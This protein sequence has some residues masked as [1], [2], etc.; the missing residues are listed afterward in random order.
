MGIR[1]R[2]CSMKPPDIRRPKNRHP[3]LFSSRGVDK[4]GSCWLNGYWT[5]PDEMICQVSAAGSQHLPGSLLAKQL[6]GSKTSETSDLQGIKVKL[7]EKLAPHPDG[8]FLPRF[9]PS[10][11]SNGLRNHQRGTACQASAGRQ[12]C[13]QKQ[14]CSRP[15][16]STWVVSVRHLL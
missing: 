1:T 5:L 2:T 3:C 7:P 16:H 12:G 8:P 13:D 10:L 9:L 15:A 14:R 11:L 6:L 4:I